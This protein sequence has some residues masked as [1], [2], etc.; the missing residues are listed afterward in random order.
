[1]DRVHKQ[2][3]V[4]FL[5]DRRVAHVR[6]FM[7]IRKSKKT[8][9]NLREIRT[10]AHDAP[11]FMVPIPRCEAFK[12]SICYNGSVE[13]NGRSVDLRNTNSYLLFKQKQK[14]CMLKPLGLI[15]NA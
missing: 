9:L 11:V 13:W 12:R 7:Y 5:E 15:Q 4:A 2:T 14:M 6:N 1:M 8:L 3:N 10:R